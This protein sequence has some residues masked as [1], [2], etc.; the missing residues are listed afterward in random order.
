MSWG[1]IPIYF[2]WFDDIDGKIFY[3]PFDKKSL[4]NT[5]NFISEL[6]NNKEKLEAFL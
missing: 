4:N 5:R 1:A 6:F 2:S 3:N